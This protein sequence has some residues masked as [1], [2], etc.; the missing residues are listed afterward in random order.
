MEELSSFISAI[1][2][3]LK[4]LPKAWAFMPGRRSGGQVIRSAAVYETDG[5]SPDAPCKVR[6]AAPRP[7]D[8]GIPAGI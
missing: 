4:T 6:A 3:S 1:S 5:D 2:A 8:P 7:L